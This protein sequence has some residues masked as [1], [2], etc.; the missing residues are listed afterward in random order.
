MTVQLS[1]PVRNAMLDVMESTIGTSP[2]MR[3]YTGAPPVNC[4]AART[5][6]LL[7]DTALPLDWQGAAV[8]GIKALAGTWSG[9]GLAAAGAGTAAGHYALMDSAGTTCHEQGTVSVSVSG[10]WVGTT[11]Y[12]AGVRVS[13]GGNVYSCAT[14]GTSAATG[15]PSG[16]G[17]GIVDNTAAWN[18]IS[19]LGDL[20]LDNVSIASGQTVT[21]NSFSKTA[22]N[23]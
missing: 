5:G 12:T 6:T 10:A 14:A 21:I 19:A 15:G 2:K 23:A 18:Y 20:T 16:A 9:T 13:N 17:S 3:F 22:P 4:A 11:A 7:Y 1:V 8:G